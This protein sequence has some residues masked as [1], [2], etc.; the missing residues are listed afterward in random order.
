MG[1]ALD[2]AGERVLVADRDL[3]AVVAVDLASGDRVILSDATIGTGPAL[4]RLVDIAIDATGHRALV[5]SD[6]SAVIAVDFDSGDRT[7]VSDASVG[8][9][10]PFGSIYK[11]AVDVA[12]NRLLVS[13]L[14]LTAVLAVDLSTGDRTI[15]A[16]G[17]DSPGALEHPSHIVIDRSQNRAILFED[18]P[19]RFTISAIDLEAVLMRN[20][21]EL[22]V[23][24]RGKRVLLSVDVASGDRVEVLGPNTGPGATLNSMQG[25]ALLGRNRVLIGSGSEPS[26]IRSFHLRT[27][28]EDIDGLH[29][30]DLDTGDREV[31]F[32]GI[33]LPLNPDGDDGDEDQEEADLGLVAV[34]E[35][36]DQAVVVDRFASAAFTLDLATGEHS[37]LTSRY[38]GL[39]PVMGRVT[40]IYLDSKHDRIIAADR[41]LGGL[42]AIDRVTGDRVVIAR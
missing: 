21:R 31:I 27:G 15:L 25:L 40:A 10:V 26:E 4:S 9:G 20:Q 35:G 8:A 37:V 24:E 14:G 2:R 32:E 39:G 11:L 6:F 7:I 42:V 28:D 13:D 16:Q 38:H 29:A 19:Y 30:V 22:L 34:D 23:T 17:D 12:A 18:N 41:E 36:N 3:A 33:Y 1:L 5:T